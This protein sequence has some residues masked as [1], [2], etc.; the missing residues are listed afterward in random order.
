MGGLLGLSSFL[1]ARVAESRVGS[2]WDNYGEF[3]DGCLR[4][5][6]GISVLN[7]GPLDPVLLLTVAVFAF[8]PQLLMAVAG[9]LLGL[10]VGWS[11]WSRAL[12][13]KLFA[14]IGILVLNLAAWITAWNAL[15]AQPPWLPFGVTP[16]GLLLQLGLCGQ[17]L[18]QKAQS[19]KAAIKVQS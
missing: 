6:Y 4:S 19:Q 18:F 3:I 1:Y 10:S 8:L 9:G 7:R 5:Y 12:T 17:S 14:M 15:P 16:G 11:A 13:F 2:L